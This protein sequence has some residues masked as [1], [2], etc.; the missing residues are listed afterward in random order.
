MLRLPPVRRKSNL[1]TTWTILNTITRT[2]SNDGHDLYVFNLIFAGWYFR[3]SRIK[4]VIILLNDINS[5][6]STTVCDYVV[7]VSVVIA[8]MPDRRDLSLLPA[9]HWR[10]T[11]LFRIPVSSE[12]ESLMTVW[13]VPHSD[14]L[15]IDIVQSAAWIL[16]MVHSCDSVRMPPID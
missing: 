2:S 3:D 15:F 11:A 7:P 4:Y 13:L 10:K 14:L 12:R 9:V 8:E 6:L 5:L 1:R 16:R